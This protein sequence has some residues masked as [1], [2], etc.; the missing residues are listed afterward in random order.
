MSKKSGEQSR[1]ART[2]AL[3]E[4]QRRRERTR[5][6]AVVGAVVAV[7]LVI[8]GV[9]F[10]I[11]QRQDT[12]GQAADATP[13]GLAD[14]YGIVW[15]KADAPRTI[16]IYEDLQC[17]VCEQFE[18]ATRDAVAKAVA[19]GKVKV[20]YRM[21]SFLDRASTNEYSS[22]ALNAAMAV[23]DAGGVDAWKK[24]HDA[25]YENQPEEGTA[26]PD[27]SALIDDAVAAGVKRSDVE[28]AIK[29]KVYAQWIVN[30]T[31]QMSKN[32][33][34]GTPTAFIDGKSAGSTP[35]ETTQAVLDAVK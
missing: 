35:A 5:N 18:T 16:T 11:S 6:L 7:L 21:V 10:A 23:Y 4:A 20:D 8:L 32:G 15:G 24:F 19:A 14:G 34:S 29:D 28:Q 25:L 26:G 1:A 13:T 12:S 33:V 22:R 31:D 17:P 27:D 3:L 2:Q 30:A 9:G